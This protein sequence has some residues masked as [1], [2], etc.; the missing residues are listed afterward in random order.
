MHI[1][2]HPRVEQQATRGIRRGDLPAMTARPRAPPTLKHYLAEHPA[3]IY[4][5]RII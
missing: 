1:R 4:A 3:T 2:S 5:A